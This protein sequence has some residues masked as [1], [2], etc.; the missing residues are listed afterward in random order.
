[1]GIRTNEAMKALGMKSSAFY[2]LKDKMQI[3]AFNSF[4]TDEDFDRMK[5]QHAADQENRRGIVKHYYRVSVREY[6]VYMVKHVALTK[7]QAIKQV[8]QYLDQG[9]DAIMRCC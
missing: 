2:K 9:Y 8:Q 4:I 6:D 5:E 7:E 1:M 3:K